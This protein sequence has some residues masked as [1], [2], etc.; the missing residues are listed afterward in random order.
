MEF[1]DFFVGFNLTFFPL[2]QLGL[3]AM[4]RRVYTYLPETGWGL[5]NFVATIGAAILGLA[6]LMFLINVAISWR[7]GALAGANPW[8][9]DTLEW[10]VPSPAPSITIST[11]DGQ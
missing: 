9:A 8:Q 2:H 4:P 3:A 6:V 1:L 11:A 5:L 7:R 10:P